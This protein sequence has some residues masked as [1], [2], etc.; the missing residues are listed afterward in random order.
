AFEVGENLVVTDIGSRK[1]SEIHTDAVCVDGR[2]VLVE[3]ILLGSL[4][5]SGEPR[6]LSDISGVARAE[7]NLRIWEQQ[8]DVVAEFAA[9]VEEMG[10]RRN[11][12]SVEDIQ[13]RTEDGVE[14]GRR[15][16]RNGGWIDWICLERVV[17]EVFIA[18]EQRIEAVP[19]HFA[20]AQSRYIVRLAA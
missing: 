10:R 4:V 12:R 17:P 11:D 15:V 13:G 16:G 5:N 1:Q 2:F 9:G 14:P 8:Q 19:L 18:A 3:Q 20:D 6:T 7:A